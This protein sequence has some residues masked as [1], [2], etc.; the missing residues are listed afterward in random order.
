VNYRRKLGFRRRKPL[1]GLRLVT[2]LPPKHIFG[3]NDLLK[4][5]EQSIALRKLR[6]V[7]HEFNTEAVYLYDQAKIEQ[8]RNDIVA[9]RPDA[10]ISTPDAAFV[11][12]GG[13]LSDSTNGSQNR[14]RNPFIDKLEYLLCCSGILP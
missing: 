2:T 5:R 7:V 3:G 14:Y 11:L 9:F 4:A 13:M 8:Q 12:Q 10:V 6:A 1:S